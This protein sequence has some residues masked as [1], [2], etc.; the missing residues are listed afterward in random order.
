MFKKIYLIIAVIVIAVV[1]SIAAVLS[2]P[3]QPI[4]SIK[5]VTNLVPGDT[6]TYSIK[7]YSDFLADNAS[8]PAS[9]KELNQT[10]FYKVAICSV[11]GPDIKFN[12]TWRF[13]N[14][15]EINLQGNGN[16]L[17]GID[18]TQFWAIYRS[19]LTLYDLVRPSGE[20]GMI[21]N[22]TETRTYAN[23][24]RPANVMTY[25]T[26]FLDTNDPSLSR[27]VDEYI[28]V[29][30]DKATGMLVELKDMQIYSDQVVLTVEWQLEQTNVWVV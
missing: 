11:L 13:L 27:A 24:L 19:N 1:I 6:F 16:L 17:K 30:F 8:E 5:A 14:G 21:V 4:P 12:T 18:D 26:Q 28:Y 23:G 22:Q 15:T 25:Q 10:D 2:I 9:F 20:D 29:H 3:N 7:G